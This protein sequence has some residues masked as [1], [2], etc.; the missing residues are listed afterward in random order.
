[1]P[2]D[3]LEKIID[4]PFTPSARRG[5]TSTPGSSASSFLSLSD[6]PSSYAGK[7][8]YV[9]KVKVGEDGLEFALGSGTVD[10]VNGQVGV[11]VLDADDIDDAATTNKF[12]TAAELALIASAVQPGDLA[13]VAFSGD[14]ADLSGTPTVYTQEQIEDFVAA[15]FT[16][17]SGRVQFSYNDTT[18][19]LTAILDVSA[20]DK[21]LYSTGADAWAETAI[22]SFGRSLI[23]DADAATARAT[24]GLVIGTNVQAQDATLA[25][26]AALGTAADKMLYTTGIDT[27]AEAAI[28]SFART[29]LDDTTQGAMQTTLGLTQEQ[30]EDWVGALLVNGNGI[31][32]TYNDGTPSIVAAL[33]ALTSDWTA[34]AARAIVIGTINGDIAA[35]GDLVL[36]G[37]TSATRTS[38]YVLLQPNGGKVGI[39][40]GASAPVG[41]LEIADTIATSYVTST[42]SGTGDFAVFVVRNDQGDQIQYFCFGGGYSGSTFG[43][44]SARYGALLMAG[45]NSNGL[46]IG[47]V[48]NKPVIFGVNNAEVMRLLSTGLTLANGKT[49]TVETL[50][51][52]D[53]DGITFKDD[54]GNSALQVTDGG[55][56]N[57]LLTKRVSTQFDKTNNTLADITGLSVALPAAGNFRFRAR[58]FVKT[59]A[60]AGVGAKVGLAYSGTTSTFRAFGQQ[61]HTGTT[62]VGNVYVTAAGAMNTSGGSG[63]GT[64]EFYWIEGYLVSTGAG[65]LTVQFAQNTTNAT[66]SSV[67]TGSTLE[68]WQLT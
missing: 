47:T 17:N 63:A 32:L 42:G 51:A 15:Q 50:A 41:N 53:G 29:L 52:V 43:I 10:S 28:T 37:T 7:G 2:K 40:P 35:N 34:G 13:T 9:I 60:I 8:G 21:I 68:I 1:M 18:G 61:T 27:W 44:P 66:A 23:D 33:T 58:L 67:L 62:A 16:G 49:L 46:M 38:S 6:T 64:D 5:G 24:L 3:T 30:I 39:G 45:T 12:A 22:S 4:L 36:Q 48:P 55:Y 54:G 14:Y 26:I 25:S 19:V 31:A 11:V 20:A 57:Y 59:P 56:L 65:N